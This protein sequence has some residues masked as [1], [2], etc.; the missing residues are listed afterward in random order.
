ML[1]LEDVHAYYGKSHVLQGISLRVEQSEIVSLLGRNGAGKTTT[2]NTIM[3]FVKSKSGKIK[4]NGNNIDK[5]PPYK[6]ARLGIGYVPQGRFILPE[7]TVEENMRLACLTG[8]MNPEVLSRIYDLFPFLRERL[9]QWGGTL[10]GGQQQM[11]AIARVMMQEPKIIF[12][13]EPTEG[14]QP[15]IITDIKETIRYLKKQGISVLL[16][17]QIAK[18]ALELSDKIYIIE[19]G[20]IPY[21]GPPD[22]LRRNKEILLQYLGVKTENNK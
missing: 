12:M 9:N 7:F 14:L 16:V 6:I 22:E 8:K 17:D 11:L 20:L 18:M 2:F 13:D 10:S 15:S 21:S 1:E 3:G 4:F 19:K 5:L